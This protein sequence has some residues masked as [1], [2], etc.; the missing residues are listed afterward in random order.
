M[1]D[2]NKDSKNQTDTDSKVDVNQTNDSDIEVDKK[3]TS[4]IEI[5]PEIEALINK[6]ASKL[7]DKKAGKAISTALENFKKENEKAQLEKDGKYQELY[8]KLVLEQ[9]EKELLI[10]KSKVE[11]WVSENNLNEYSELFEDVT[12]LE[13]AMKIGKTIKEKEEAR[14]QKLLDERLNNN[15]PVNKSNT[16]VSQLRT[17]RTPDEAREILKSLGVAGY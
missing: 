14:I 2:L 10:S 15:A 12:D 5:T 7:F 13:K 6:E 1:E 9:K 17:G 3:N 4:E 11:K 16:N 8:E